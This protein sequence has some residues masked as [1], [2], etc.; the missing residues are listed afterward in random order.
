M[1]NVRIVTDST[2]ELPADVVEALEITVVPWHIQLDGETLP[3]VPALRTSEF[4][5]RRSRAQPVAVPPNARQFADAFE[6]CT[7][8][9][10]EIVAILPSSRI[11][12]SLQAARQARA[13]FVGRCEVQLVDSQFISCALGALVIEAARAARAQ[14][15]AAEI[16]RYVNGLIT[17]TYFAFHAESPEQMLRHSLIEN[18]PA[19]LGSPSGY[20]PLLL[21]E[22]GEIVP[23]PRSRKRGDPIERMVEFVGEFGPLEHFWTVSTGLHHGLELLHTRLS[24]ELP[25]KLYEDHVYGPVMAYYLGSTIL[26]V[27]A[28]EALL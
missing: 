15:S 9:S 11:A 5:R 24:E 26:G 22:Q 2:A 10:R 16:V 13:E 17:R 1:S 4:H 23:L 7:R 27:V 12:L 28:I 18:S 19:A 8:A 14:T 21:L 20:R 25:D 6:R 3:D